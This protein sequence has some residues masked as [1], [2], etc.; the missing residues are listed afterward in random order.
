MPDHYPLIETNKTI[1]V[2]GKVLDLSVPAVM[3]IINVTPDSFY[4]GSRQQQLEQIVEQARKMI[5]QGATFIDIGGSSSRPGAAEISEDEEIKR[6]IPALEAILKVLP[7]ANISIDTF[8]ASVARKAVETGACLINDIS[9]G[10]LDRNMFETVSSLQVPYILMHMR[11]TP[12]T[13]ASQSK[14]DD[15]LLDI[16]NYFQQKV[17]LL[18][19]LGLKDI[20]L[21]VGFGFAKNIEQNYYLLSHL[22]QFRIFELPLMAG[23]SRKSLIYKKLGIAVEEALNGTTVLNALALTKGV[24]LLRVHDVKEAVETVKLFTL[25]SRI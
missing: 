23:L 5:E 21:D 7:Q 4:A 16:V 17:Y 15:L 13:M 24:S 19:Q 6:V 2:N 22:D 18:R 3:G 25:F 1:L 8:R 9:G 14:Y 11:G 10:E 12:Q 20:I